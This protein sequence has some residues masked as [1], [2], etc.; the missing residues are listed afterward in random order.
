MA[1]MVLQ[2]MPCLADSF[3][4]PDSLT[5]GR[6]RY[7]FEEP[8]IK[9]AFFPAYR[10]A[11][12]ISDT[13]YGLI[14]LRVFTF[15][16]PESLNEDLYAPPEKDSYDLFVRHFHRKQDRFV[17]RIHDSHPR[18]RPMAEEGVEPARLKEWEDWSRREQVSVFIDVF[19]DTLMDRYQLHLFKS[20]T[21]NYAWSMDEWKPS[22][23]LLGAAVGG[24]FLFY[25]GL[26]ASGALGPLR[27]SIDVT[28]GRRIMRSARDRSDLSRV[29]SLELGYKDIPL[30]LSTGYGVRGGR[31]R[32]ETIALKFQ[33]RF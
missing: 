5:G 6:N 18:F 14:S 9:Q 33:Q 29:G 17:R 32:R 21:E 7:L 25:N 11:E 28:S 12:G 31:L 27:L 20:S 15:I 8:T 4:L 13:L 3:A 16:L 23:I 1:A 2:A 22:Y 24:G 10:A 30:K 19:R 26:H